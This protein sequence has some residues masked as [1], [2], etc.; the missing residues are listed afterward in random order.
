MMDR[1]VIDFPQPDSPTSPSASPGSMVRSALPTAWTTDLVSWICVDRSLICRTGGIRAT[2]GS[3]AGIGSAGAG[4]W[5]PAA[6]P[7]VQR[8]PDRVTQQVAGHYDHDDADPDR[9]DLPPVTVLQVG[10]P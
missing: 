10:D 3:A 9:V 1:P 4:R 8:V 7:D 2:P 6:Q 5:S